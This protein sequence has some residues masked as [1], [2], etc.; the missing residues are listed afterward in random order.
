VV[1]ASINPSPVLRHIAFRLIETLIVDGIT[2]DALKESLLL[3]LITESPYPQMRSAAVGIL[4]T[5]IANALPAR[6]AQSFKHSG[7]ASPS[8]LRAITPVV[9][10]AGSL[11]FLGLE[12]STRSPYENRNEAGSERQLRKVSEFIRAFAES[13]EPGRLV[14]ALNLYYVVLSRDTKNL[15]RGEP[16]QLS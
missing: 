5:A 1:H 13:P 4:R 2:D 6:G 14:E 3:E 12:P 8:I 15:V 11:R 7:F 10:D 9:F 16:L